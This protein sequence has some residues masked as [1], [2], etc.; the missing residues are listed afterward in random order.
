MQ[1]LMDAAESG[2]VFMRA[3]EKYELMMELQAD[4]TVEEVNR[5]VPALALP[6]G[7]GCALL[8]TNG[9]EQRAISWPHLCKGWLSRVVR[10]RAL[11]RVGL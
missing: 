10:A 1:N 9:S 11:V 4:I 5:W 6:L 7:A 8:L 2:D 3:R